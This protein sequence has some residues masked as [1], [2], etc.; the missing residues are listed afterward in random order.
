MKYWW[1]ILL[2]IVLAYVLGYVNGCRSVH[3]PEIGTYPV[4]KEKKEIHPVSKTIK[5]VSETKP[6]LR[7]RKAPSVPAIPASV[8]SFYLPD[9]PCDNLLQELYTNRYYRNDYVDSAMNITV[10]D[11]VCANT[12]VWRKVEYKSLLPEI[13]VVKSRKQV[14]ALSGTV[15]FNPLSGPSVGGIVEWKRLHVGVDWHPIYNQYSGR[16]G[17]VI[18]RK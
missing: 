13:P 10:Q 18:F 9:G 15:G 17:Y 3:C 8:D 16:V 14:F 5:P 7:K 4:Q 2:V 11:S 1:I 6:V 12:L